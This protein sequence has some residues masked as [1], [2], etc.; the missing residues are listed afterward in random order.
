MSVKDDWG[1]YL[2]AR[3]AV[4]R[5]AGQC[6]SCKEPA[7]SGAFCAAHAEAHRVE[8]REYNARRRAFLLAAQPVI[9]VDAAT[10]RRAKA[11]A[12]QLDVP[13]PVAFGLAI[14]QAVSAAERHAMERQP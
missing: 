1:A 3:R 10:Y 9:D 14:E 2:R 11:R 7:A 4:K 6:R 8:Q 13:L 5:A 12:E